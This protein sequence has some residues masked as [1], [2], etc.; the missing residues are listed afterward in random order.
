MSHLPPFAT[1]EDVE[2]EYGS[3]L[4]NDDLAVR[5]EWLLDK[6]SLLIRSETGSSWVDDDNAL[7]GDAL[8]LDTFQHV[9]TS[10]VVRCLH[11][12]SGIVQE[13][14][15]PFSQTFSADSSPSIYLTKTEKRMLARWGAADSRI[16]SLT[17]VPTTRGAVETPN[18]TC[19]SLGEDAAAILE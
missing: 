7:E 16:G 2:A 3:A 1:V 14:A 4:A 19:R 15:G 10:A 6:A 5:V 18:V 17:T 12:P 9:A 8:A 11:N 13:A